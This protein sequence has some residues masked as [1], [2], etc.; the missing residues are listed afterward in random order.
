MENLARNPEYEYLTN[1]V[2][3]QLIEASNDG[4][5][6]WNIKTGD[7]YFSRRWAE[8]LGYRQDEIKQHV[9]SWEK[10]VHPDDMGYVM[11]VLTEH[12]SGVTDFYETEHRVRCKN[13][14]WKWILDRGRVIQRDKD[15]NPIRAAGSHT[16]VTDKKLHAQELLNLNGQL[17]TA[18]NLRNQFLSIASHELKTPLTSLL[19]LIQTMK[20]TLAL[21][22]KQLVLTKVTKSVLLIEKQLLFL[23]HLIDDML[24]I[25]RLESGKFTINRESFELSELI[26]DCS[27]R[28]DPQ[29]VSATGKSLIVSETPAIKVFWDRYRMDQVLTN[30]ITNAVRYGDG[31]PISLKVQTLDRHVLISVQDSGHGIDKVDQERIFNLFERADKEKSTRGLGLGL[32]ISRE[33]VQAH[34]GRIWVESHLKQGSIFYIDMPVSE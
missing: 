4:F 9:S 26:K 2:A 10:L 29:I 24:D 30:L 17:Q 33:I 25:S 8:M 32:Y 14:D 19:L 7:V 12:L 5:W 28:N 20:R 23:V 21:D 11:K 6:D 3:Y 15:N 31:K 18:I 27:E 13:G 22:D 16:D 1:P 34:G